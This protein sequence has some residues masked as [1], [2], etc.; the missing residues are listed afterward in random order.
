[1]T[2]LKRKAFFFAL[3]LLPLV[4]T[5]CKDEEGN[6]LTVDDICPNC[7]WSGT[8]EP[9]AQME[10]DIQLEEVD[11]NNLPA[12]V[13]LVPGMPPIGNQGQYGTCVAWAVAYG[14]RSYL[15]GRSNGLTASQMADPNNQF[16]PK[17][18]FWALPSGEKGADCN[19]SYFE[20]ALDLLVSRGVARMSTV[21]YENL[22]DCSSS[23][24]SSWTSDAGSYKIENYRRI[25]VAVTSTNTREVII[26]QIKNY[27]AQGRVIIFGAKLGDGFMG[28]NDASVISSDGPMNGGQHGYHAMT[29]VGYDNSRG[30]NGAFRVF[31]S[32]DT[33][34]GDNGMIW[35][36]YNF[37]VDDFVFTAFVAKAPGNDPD[38]NNDGTVDPENVATG[39]DLVAWEITDASTGATTRNITYNVFNSGSTTINA[40]VDWST[41]Y[42]AYNAYDPNDPKILLFD[43]YSDDFGSLGD[44]GAMNTFT[45]DQSYFRGL[46]DNWFS[47]VNVT[48]GQS[49]AQAVFGQQAPNF[50]WGYS[51]PSDLNGE[52]YLVLIADAFDDIRD[53]ADEDNNYLFATGQEPV[54]VVNGVIDGNIGKNRNGIFGFVQ[55]GRVPTMSSRNSPC[56][57]AIGPNTRNTYSPEEIVSVIRHQRNSGVLQKK[58]REYLAQRGQVNNRPR[59]AGTR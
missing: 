25:D 52:F 28:W 44:Q 3:A 31:N 48:S 20:P 10:Q 56:P 15:H 39:A 37:F 19:G 18:L 57:T 41:V 24:Q 16:S 54:T 35:V 6:P 12:S 17:D 32:W 55:N 13:N 7:G 27:L 53:E 46:S 50:D 4:M 22:G 23:P 2:L 51:L 59:T 14:G 21:P 1:M 11:P 42:V 8:G 26:N 34:W 33:N 47:H 58:V 30:N 9:I 38:P 36:D 40:S 49:V 29:V 5:G 43:Y 45:S